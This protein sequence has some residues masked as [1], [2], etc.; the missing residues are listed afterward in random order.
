MVTTDKSW[1]S[2]L[3]VSLGASPF[4]MTGQYQQ[5]LISLKDQFILAGWTVQRCSNGTTVGATDLWGSTLANVVHNTAGARSW[6]ALGA[7][8]GYANGSAYSILIEAYSPP[9]TINSPTNPITYRIFTSSTAFT[10][11]TTTGPPTGGTGATTA[12][13]YSTSY[14]AATDTPVQAYVNFWRTTAGDVL[15]IN[16][17]VST[18]TYARFGGVFDA[19]NARSTANRLLLLEDS[20]GPFH[21][22]SVYGYATDNSSV[23][24]A[25]ASSRASIVISWPNGQ[26]ST[27]NVGYFPL[28]VIHNGTSSLTARDYGILPDIW[29]VS[30]NTPDNATDATDTDPMRLL[31]IG[32][33]ALPTTFSQT[34]IL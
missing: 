25:T 1:T 15:W 22:P 19:D 32:G 23:F 7:P 4:S 33:I 24:T 17:Q 14:S 34:P 21:V 28:F 5:L 8:S 3:N 29:G 18:M 9:G 20:S 2:T 12:R 10:D 6:I 31:T 11:G 27:A 30:D 16:K 13:T 26:D